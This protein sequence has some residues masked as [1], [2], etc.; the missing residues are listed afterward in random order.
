[1]GRNAGRNYFLTTE[2]G[3]EAYNL[4]L[5]T[6]NN[7]VDNESL[8]NLPLGSENKHHAEYVKKD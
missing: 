5:E 3:T 8:G 4:Y 6:I 2:G 7:A 1:M